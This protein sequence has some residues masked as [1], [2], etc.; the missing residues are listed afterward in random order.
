MANPSD[1]PLML[2][3]SG[4]RG[5]VGAS[6][7]PEVATDYAAGFACHVGGA[8]GSPVICLG[9]DTR[10]SSEMLHE[11]AAAGLAATGARVVDVGVVPTPTVAVMVTELGAAG[12]MMVTASHNPARWNG[13]KCISGEGMALPAAGIV[14]VI[15]RF[16]TRDFRW[17]APEA[18]PPGD[19]DDRGAAIHVARVLSAVKPTSGGLRVAFDPN[20]GAGCVAGRELL[21]QLGCDVITINGE[22]DGRFAHE[23]EPLAENLES[24][25]R[26]TAAEAADLGFGLDPDA[27]RLAIIDEQGR[28]IGEEYTL[29]LAARRW[30]DLHGPAPIV[31]NLST[32]RMVDDLVRGYPGASVHRTPVGEVN[33]AVEMKRTGAPIGGEGNGGVIL[34]RV[35]W[36]RDSLAAMALVHGLVA[37]A[38]RP[39]SALVSELPQYVM[40]KHRFELTGNRDTVATAVEKVSRR[41]ADEDVNTADGVRVDVDDGWVHLRPSNTEPIIRLIAEAATRERAWEL[42]DEV[43]VAAGLT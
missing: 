34:P 1:A 23:L 43:A 5:I 39:L 26:A 8:A 28:F 10:G 15:R 25:A 18:I 42:I 11:A 17:A 36:I 41:F 13:L 16:R 35:C 40:I 38:G 2:S 19:R 4:A 37:E 21:G 6:M 31:V 12:G 27:D 14:D 9:R 22:P 7:T 24:L 3:V 33:V 20:H 29:V 32:S 30:M